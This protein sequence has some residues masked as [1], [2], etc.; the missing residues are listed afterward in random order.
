[1]AARKIG[2][3]VGLLAGVALTLVVLQLW[4][5][6]LDRT[7][8][9][10]AQP[11]GLRPVRHN[12]EAVFPDSSK[13]LP[14]AWLPEFTG[15]QHDGWRVRG[16]GGNEVT[17]GDFKGKVVFL[18]FWSTTCEPCIAEMPGIEG[19]RISQKD[20]KVAFL[21]VTEDDD[22]TVREF[23]KKHTL[24]VPVYLSSDKP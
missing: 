20:E 13:N 8:S 10:A 24:Q 7:I 5:E 3:A 1:M 16:L 21:A 22:S 19:L 6:Y 15:Q 12:Q 23:L 14:A 17:L 2:F 9:E 18:N 11:R 4:G